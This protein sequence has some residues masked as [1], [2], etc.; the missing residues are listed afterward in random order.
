M[1]TANVKINKINVIKSI[2]VSVIVII[3]EFIC[4][5]INMVMI[6]FMF[7]ADLTQVFSNAYLKTLYG[8][9]SLVLFVFSTI[10][11]SLLL[12]K[13]ATVDKQSGNFHLS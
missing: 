12:N 8:I 2:Q 7:K 6:K 1:I 10:I 13:K 3:I 11:I 9:P 5:M 4:E